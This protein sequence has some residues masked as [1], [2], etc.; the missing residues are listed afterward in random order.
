MADFLGVVESAVILI[1]YPNHRIIA[2]LRVAP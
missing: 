1:T 2:E